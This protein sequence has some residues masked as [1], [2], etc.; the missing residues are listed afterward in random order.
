MENNINEDIYDNVLNESIEYKTEKDVLKIL[1]AD[2]D[3]NF[4]K[5][6]RKKFNLLV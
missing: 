6:I 3:I 1:I 2:P 5:K 4:I